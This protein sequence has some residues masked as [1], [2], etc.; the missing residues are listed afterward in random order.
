MQIPFNP[1]ELLEDFPQMEIIIHPNSKEGK[2]EAVLILSD[3]GD[4]LFIRKGKCLEDFMPTIID[5]C[6]IL[7]QPD[8]DY[9]LDLAFDAG[10]PI[11]I[12]GCELVDNKIS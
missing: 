12:Y 2:Y 8:T 4:S 9:W 10:E 7:N 5:S 11:I 6:R 1:E 3:E